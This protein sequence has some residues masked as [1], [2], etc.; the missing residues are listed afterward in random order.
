MRL[1]VFPGLP[2]SRG[3]LRTG[4]F[5]GTQIRVDRQLTNGGEHF[6]VRRELTGRLFGEGEPAVH[7]DLEDPAAR[8]AQADLGGRHLGENPVPR[9]TGARFVAS[10]SAVYDFNLHADLLVG[11]DI[12][13][14]TG[15]EDFR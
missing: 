2:P 13:R 8:S 10:H 14:V 4:A 3:R 11:I 9:R 7:R 5:G 6:L 1:S 12:G 15:R